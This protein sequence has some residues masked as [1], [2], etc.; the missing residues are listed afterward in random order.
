MA[1]IFGG[2][3]NPLDQ[4]GLGK[5]LVVVECAIHA[6]FKILGHSQQPRL[7]LHKDL[8]GPGCQ[9]HHESAFLQ[10]LQQFARAG[11]Q[12]FLRIRLALP[13]ALHSG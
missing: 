10:L 5:A 8:I 11:N 7:F 2:G 1:V 12:I 4:D 9:I 13:Q 6:A 3:K